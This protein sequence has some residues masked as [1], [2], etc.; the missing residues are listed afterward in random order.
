MISS[1]HSAK[2]SPKVVA[3]IPCF[4]TELSIADV[5]SRARKYVDQVI[6]IDDGS[7]DGTIEVAKAAGALVINHGTNRGYGIAVKSCFEAAEANAADVLVILDGDGQHNPD[8]LPRLL[9]PVL[10]GEAD[11][12]IGSRFIA[13]N[14]NMPRYRKFGISVIN[15]LWNFGSKVKVS[16]TQSGF[17]VYRRGVLQGVSL[18]E[19]GMSVSVETL[20][21]I[22][23]KGATI[24]EVP[25]SCLY[26]PSV[27]NMGA[28]RHGL[29]VALSVIRIRAKSIRYKLTRGVEP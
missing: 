2:T 23:S 3:A 1:H 21:K 13:D 22:R 25:I 26:V 12:T 29:R 16:D 14:H 28:I 19:T 6:V 9:A 20:E 4:N 27:L 7:R 11:L 17:R 24:K 5:V 18:V 8:E 10:R 15:F